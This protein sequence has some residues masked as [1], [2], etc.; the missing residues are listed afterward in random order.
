MIFAIVGTC[1]DFVSEARRVS[2]RIATLERSSGVVKT[3]CLIP[4]TAVLLCFSKIVLNI[5][6]KRLMVVERL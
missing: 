1:L 3:F 6:E 4:G 5:L 2:E